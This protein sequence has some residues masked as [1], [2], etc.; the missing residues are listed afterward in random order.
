MGTGALDDSDSAVAIKGGTFDG[1][2]EYQNKTK[3]YIRDV[4]YANV[5]KA[6]ENKY[7]DKVECLTEN[8]WYD[9]VRVGAEKVYEPD[10]NDDG[11]CD[12]TDARMALTAALNITDLTVKQFEEAD[13]TQNRKIELYDA[14][15]ILKIAL[16]VKN[17]WQ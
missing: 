16:K 13:V 2:K 17:V 9:G 5:K 10:I 12:L 11:K 1:S 4:D 8:D 7:G 3:V 6:L 15:K 14:Q